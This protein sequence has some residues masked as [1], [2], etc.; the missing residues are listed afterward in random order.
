MPDI[1]KIQR[2]VEKSKGLQ[3]KITAKEIDILEAVLRHELKMY[4]ELQCGTPPRLPPP[5]EGE[6]HCT[7]EVTKGEVLPSSAPIH[8]VEELICLRDRERA[9]YGRPQYSAM[10]VDTF[11]GMNFL[12]NWYGCAVLPDQTTGNLYRDGND[13]NLHHSQAPGCTSDSN[14]TSSIYDVAYNA[15]L[16]STINQGNPNAGL[17]LFEKS[18][19]VDQSLPPTLTAESDGERRPIFGELDSLIHPEMFP[20]DGTL[21]FELDLE[22]HDASVFSGHHGPNGCGAESNSRLSTTSCGNVALKNLL[23]GG[24]NNSSNS[25]GASRMVFPV[26]EWWERRDEFKKKPLISRICDLKTHS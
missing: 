12:H 23:E 26:K 16:W 14:P 24:P 22:D 25:V 5:L 11:T 13:G 1:A 17:D 21:S 19:E 15:D 20:S 3:D 18:L 2:L 6:S 9:T 8:V 10:D 7:E 4:L